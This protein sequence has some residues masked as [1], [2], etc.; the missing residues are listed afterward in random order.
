MNV[1]I[2]VLRLEVSFPH[3]PTENDLTHFILSTGDLHQNSHDGQL[4]PLFSFSIE[5][6]ILQVGGNL[7]PK[8]V[9]LY[10]WLH[11]NVA[12]M[13]TR[14]KAASIPIGQVIGSAEI[15]FGKYIKK[16]YSTVKEQYNNYVKLTNDFD[17]SI[18][19]NVPLLRF[20]T[21]VIISPPHS[22]VLIIIVLFLDVEKEDQGNDWL[23]LIIADII[24]RHNNTIKNFYSVFQK[25]K[26]LNRFLSEEPSKIL[27][28]EVDLNSAIITSA[29]Y[30]SSTL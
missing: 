30:V 16:L 6:P 11:L 9:E 24:T 17:V 19:D 23:Y 14:S 18:A 2:F 8:L 5:C 1:N 10:R 22:I 29:E 20:L 3:L 27:P 26:P 15:Q 25:E 13:V 12:H 4:W 28:T 7:L 21:G